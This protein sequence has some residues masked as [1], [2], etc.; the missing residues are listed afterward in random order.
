ML[1]CQILSK[2]SLDAIHYATLEVLE[3]TGVI[4]ESDKALRILEEAGCTVDYKKHIALIPPYVVEEALK[5]KPKKNVTIHAR[6]R[7]NDFKQDG[8]NIAFCTDGCGSYTLNPK[9]GTRRASTKKDVSTGARIADCLDVFGEYWPI[10]TAQDVPA[11]VRVLHDLDAALN[12]TEKH[13]EFETTMTPEEARFQIEIAASVVGGKEELRKRPIISSCHCTIAPLRHAKGPTEAAIEFAKAG[14]PVYFLPMPQAGATAPVTLAGSTVI[15][16]A[17]SLSGLVII[18]MV[19]PGAQMTYSSEASNF[20]MK[21]LRWCAGS[22]E[23]GLLTAVS[24]ELAKYY[25]MPSSAAGFTTDAKVPGAQACY[26]KTVTGTLPVF[27][28]YDIVGG[29]GLL[30][31]CTVFAP[32]QLII[33]AEIAKMLLRLAR[34]FEVNDETLA[35]DLIHKVG[36]GGHYLA[37]KHTLEYL[38][39]EHFMSE[40]S[41]R[42]PY[43][44]W[45]KA[46]SKTVVKAAGEK[47]KKIL[48]EHMPT[49]LE[50]DVQKEIEEIIKRAEKEL[51]R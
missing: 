10:V 25:E 28:G 1:S 6:N 14:V 21:A 42:D 22:P 16:N 26:E 15:A 37:E 51:A 47:A 2:E 11:H 36:S 44:A 38:E 5:K 12:N 20:D 31:A 33:D 29:L 34:G 32:E 39:K 50:K 4:V 18:Q 35:L 9:T 19:A 27:V 17:E 23:C 30:D 13:V 7:K 24:C 45:K 46:G 40:I 41:D 49:P 8:R 48:E 43:E 3:K